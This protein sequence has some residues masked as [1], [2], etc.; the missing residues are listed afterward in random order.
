MPASDRRHKCNVLGFQPAADES[1]DAQGGTVQPLRVVDDQDHGYGVSHFADELE[2]RHR[3][4]ERIR[5]EVE[6]QAEGRLE[7]L[8]L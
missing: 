2:S 5:L 7:L 3:N 8:P 1:N 4:A 6:A